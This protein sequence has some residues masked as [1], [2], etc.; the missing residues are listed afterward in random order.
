MV[1]MLIKMQ[2]HCAEISNVSTIH[3]ADAA[4]NKMEHIPLSHGS[5]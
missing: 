3:T 2:F 5:G 1:N 4:K